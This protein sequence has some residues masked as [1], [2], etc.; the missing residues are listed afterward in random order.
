MFRDLLGEG[1]EADSYDV[2]AGDYPAQVEDHDA[3]LITGSPA[4]RL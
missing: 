2:A 1:F 4:G 3:Y